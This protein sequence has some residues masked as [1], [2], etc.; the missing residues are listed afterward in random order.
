LNSGEEKKQK[1]QYKKGKS[2]KKNT[3]FQKP[4]WRLKRVILN[5]FVQKLRAEEALRV[6][7]LEER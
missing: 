7:F 4:Q 1:G 6:A 3:P 5:Q 2:S